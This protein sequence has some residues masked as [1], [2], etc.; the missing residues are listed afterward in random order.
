[1]SIDLTKFSKNGWHIFAVMDLC[2]ATLEDYLSPPGNRL[3]TTISKLITNGDKGAESSMCVQTSYC[4]LR[5]RE[6][7]FRL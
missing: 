5:P 4:S 3:R 7:Y 2:D 1:M 6:F